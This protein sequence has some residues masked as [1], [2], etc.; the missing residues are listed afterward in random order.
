MVGC[1]DAPPDS[2]P[3]QP[4]LAPELAGGGE[5][6]QLLR[7]RTRRI[8]GVRPARPAPDRSA[9]PRGR[10]AGGGNRSDRVLGHDRSPRDR[11]LDVYDEEDSDSPSTSSIT[12]RSRAMTRLLAMYTA[13]T[14]MPSGPGRGVRRLPLDRGQPEGLPGRVPELARAPV[15]P[16]SG[17]AGGD[18]RRRRGPS[19][20][21]SGAGTRSSSS[22]MSESPLAWGGRRLAARTLIIR[23]RAIRKSHPRNDPRAGSGS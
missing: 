5:P 3:Q 2:P 8:P 21:Q 10:D 13:P 18:T 15:R 23:L 14:E 11:M 17:R 20:P 4:G 7:G 19:P 9:G 1:A 6:L 16:P 12:A 22:R